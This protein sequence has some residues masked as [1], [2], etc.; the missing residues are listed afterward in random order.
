MATARF[1]QFQFDIGRARDLI[2]LG[3]GIGAMTVGR[4]DG[5]DLYRAGLVQ[6]VSALDHYVHGV[7][8]DRAVDIMLGRLPPGASGGKFGLSFTA[9][10]DILG[11]STPADQELMARTHAAER[12]RLETFQ[13]PDAIASTLALVGV[14]KVWTTVFGTGQTESVALGLVVSRRNR[15][16]HQADSDPLTLG[17]LTPLLDVDAL[18][19]IN[20]VE[21]IVTALDPHC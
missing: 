21:R 3:Q 4:V 5:S 2:G 1:G 18:D 7:V 9:V 16:V 12:L 14:S 17:A 15:I 20:T 10:S 19:A 8:L 13:R 6:A 11:A